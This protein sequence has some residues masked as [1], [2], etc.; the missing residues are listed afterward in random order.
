MEKLS[1]LRRLANVGVLI[2]YLTKE[3]I[4][5]VLSILITALSMLVEYLEL[6]DARRLKEVPT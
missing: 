6:R 2:G 1:N 4:I 5:F 3:D